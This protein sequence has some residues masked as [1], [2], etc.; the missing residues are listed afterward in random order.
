MRLFPF[1][2]AGL[3]SLCWLAAPCHASAPP[4]EE[5]HPCCTYDDLQP[6]VWFGTDSTMAMS[7][8]AAYCAPILWFSPD[9]PLLEGVDVPAGIRIPTAFPFEDVPDRPVVYYRVKRIVTYDD[10]AG[11]AFTR[12]AGVPGPATI[13]F[14]RT[15]ALDLDFFFYYPSEEGLGRHQHDVESVEMK[16]L[17]WRRKK[18]TQCPYALAVVKI[19]AKAHGVLW[20]DNT[21]EWDTQA[22][23]PMTILVEEGK[24]ASCTDKNGDG[25]YTPGFDVN[26]RV[27]DAWGVRDVIRGGGLF[28]GG[29]NSWLAKVRVPQDR[30]FP[31]LPAD[32]PGRRRLGGDAYA[33][34]YAVYELRP[35]P[36]ASRAA[37]DPTL[38]PFIA[39]KGS[40]EP[41]VEAATDFNQFVDWVSS[42]PFVKSVS[43]S[44]RYDGSFGV[45]VLFP[46]FIFKN[47]S[48]PLAGG[49]IV[50]R[51]YL[52]DHDLRDFGYNLL[53]TTS[54]SRWIDGY[55]SGGVEVDKGDGGAKHTY[56]AAETGFKF[57]ASVEHS[58]LRF[59]RPITDFWGLRI[60]LKY[61][62][63][64]PVH[65]TSL[66][67][68]LGAGT[69]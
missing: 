6:V 5:N 17:V 27:N 10:I 60:G 8:L 47:F 39:S 58:A 62:N 52:Q 66:V 61:R 69:W 30:V 46:L 3:A 33:R 44:A 42:E 35:F 13:D 29:F 53:Y 45:S 21:L 68:E 36:P 31:P 51:I 34:G 11:P 9:E 37:A 16:V 19:V 67:F 63:A 43:V 18:C 4:D 28:T 32:S 57:R 12:E 23:F 56:F 38:V 7:R 24:H 15:V 22:R 59:M 2:F 54:A 25:Y 49:W 1:L 20:Y 65:D 14:T 26:R 64:F 48:D 55:V 50:N 40:V 41:E